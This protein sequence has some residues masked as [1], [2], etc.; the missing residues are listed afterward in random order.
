[1][2]LYFGC[3]F[4]FTFTDSRQITW[5]NVSMRGHH[6][7]RLEAT[8]PRKGVLVLW[9]KRNLNTW[10]QIPRSLP[11][12]SFRV[13]NHLL[14]LCQF[15][16]NLVP[17]VPRFVA[18]ASEEDSCLSWSCTGQP[19]GLWGE[20]GS[21]STCVKP[22]HVALDH[23]V[24]GCLRICKDVRMCRVQAVQALVHFCQ[25][26]WITSW[27]GLQEKLWW[28][29]GPHLSFGLIQ[30]YSNKM[31]LRCWMMFQSTS[32]T[33]DQMGAFLVRQYHWL[34]RSLKILRRL[35]LVYMRA[36]E[37]HQRDSALAMKRAGDL[38]RCIYLSLFVCHYQ[39][40]AIEGEQDAQSAWRT[41]S[42]LCC[43]PAER[44]APEIVC[45]KVYHLNWGMSNLFRKLLQTSRWARID[46]LK[47]LKSASP[48]LLNKHV[49]RL[50]FLPITTGEKLWDWWKD[51]RDSSLPCL[52]R[53]WKGI[54]CTRLAIFSP[55]EWVFVS[56]LFQYIQWILNASDIFDL[57]CRIVSQVLQHSNVP[58]FDWK[59]PILF[60]GET[61]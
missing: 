51:E 2:F 52:N 38:L 3:S 49:K 35:R 41:E 19:R 39:A 45:L 40:E 30:I 48:Y 10:S 23:K 5:C 44:P 61:A 22:F 34:R 21:C 15:F 60:M 20:S 14:E 54:A 47:S 7:C 53:A 46:T 37:M 26:L 24:S 9:I 58:I 16:V 57:R 1:M 12:R 33:W 32:C 8:V 36:V 31:I 4:A 59:A 28:L 13:L 11:S 42:I 6:W 27:K 56:Y 29:R 55:S 17:R 50:F 43:L 18:K 25:D